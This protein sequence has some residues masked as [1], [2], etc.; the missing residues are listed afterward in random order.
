MP[1][2]IEE[3]ARLALDALVT[4]ENASRPPAS[5]H[6]DAARAD[7]RQAISALRAA[8]ANDPEALEPELDAD[9]TIRRMRLQEGD[10]LILQSEQTLSREVGERM[11]GGIREIF[12]RRG[13]SVPVFVFDGGLKVSIVNTADLP[14]VA[15]AAGEASA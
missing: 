8:F 3:A 4:L 13:I 11:I 5:E 1:I 9:L 2:T 6:L 14:V 15:P 12:E 10:A 7:A